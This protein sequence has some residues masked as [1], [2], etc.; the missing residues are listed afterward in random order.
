MRRLRVRILPLAPK[1]IIKFGYGETGN[2]VRFRILYQK[3]FESSTLSI[4]TKF[5]RQLNDKAGDCYSSR[6]RFK[7]YL[8]SQQY[9]RRY[10]LM[11]KTSDFDSDN[12]GSTP[13]ILTNG[14]KSEWLR[15][16]AATQFTGVQISP[17]PPLIRRSHEAARKSFDYRT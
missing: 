17:Q 15:W 9:I 5:V 3:Q 13:I 16:L 10:S 4:R 12:I 14:T 8:H 1:N 6:Y 7:S 11:V 2:H